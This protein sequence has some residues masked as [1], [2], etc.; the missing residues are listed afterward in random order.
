MLESASLQNC[1]ND[2]PREVFSKLG[3]QLGGSKEFTRL[4]SNKTPED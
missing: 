3:L 1:D 4:V 2:C